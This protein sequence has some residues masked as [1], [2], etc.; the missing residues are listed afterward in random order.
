MK[1][2]LVV[3]I[4]IVISILGIFVPNVKAISLVADKTNDNKINL[5]LST[6]N[7]I[8]YSMLAKFEIT[9]NGSFSRFLV[10]KCS[11]SNK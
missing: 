5:S 7:Q 4:L 6:D 1:R 2:I 8:V 10:V 3:M 11:K 9:G